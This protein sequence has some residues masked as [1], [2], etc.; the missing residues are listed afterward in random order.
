MNIEKDESDDE[1]NSRAPRG[2]RLKHENYVRILAIDGGGI[3]GVIP[4]ILLEQLESALNISK[5]GSERLCDY[6]D[7]IAGTSTGGLVAL[8]LT[9][10]RP[11]EGARPGL[12]GELVSV[13][14]QFGAQIF[15][16]SGSISKEADSLPRTLFG[17]SQSRYPS[18][19][20]NDALEKLFGDAR[21]GGAQ[22]AS[23]IAGKGVMSDN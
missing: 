15:P 3:R 12:A 14:E 11:G 6:F 10:P 20:L 9:V 16:H 19:G 17:Y 13:Y 8:W 2:E 22:T 4:A 23:P 18:I 5:D 1:T 21:F 7:M